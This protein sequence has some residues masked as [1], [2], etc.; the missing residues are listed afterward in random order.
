M[1]VIPLPC[2]VSLKI[3]PKKTCD[4][5]GVV[6]CRYVKRCPGWPLSLTLMLRSQSFIINEMESS[7][8]AVFWGKNVPVFFIYPKILM[9]FSKYLTWL[10]A[11]PSRNRTTTLQIRQMERA[12]SFPYFSFLRLL[13]PLY[14]QSIV[15]CEPGN[16]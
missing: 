3:Q 8:C 15:G 1:H 5:S 7:Y 4:L 13:H 2:N 12:F 6:L 16:T 10:L 9:F 11:C 14:R